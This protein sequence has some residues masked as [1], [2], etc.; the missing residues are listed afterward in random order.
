[1]ARAFSL[2]LRRRVIDA[3]TE[4]LS[5]REAAR[6]FRIGVSTAGSWHR[7]WRATGSI[8]PGRQGAREGSKL[9]RHEAFILDLVDVEKDITLAEIAA[10][11]STERGVRSCAATVHGFFKKRGVTFKKRR[12][13]PPSRTGTTFAPRGCVGS[14]ANPTSTRAA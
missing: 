8:Q 7:A 2:D 3:I 5:T 6:R 14:T 10:R 1:M 4:G 11:L 12:R 13:T 9:D